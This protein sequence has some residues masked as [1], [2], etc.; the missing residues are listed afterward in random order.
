MAG[1]T[2]SLPYMQSVGDALFKL[3]AAGLEWLAS[4]WPQKACK[5]KF[6]RKFW[7]IT[8]TLILGTLYLFLILQ[9]SII[10]AKVL[11]CQVLIT[12]RDLGLKLEHV[13]LLMGFFIAIFTCIN[14]TLAESVRTRCTKKKIPKKSKKVHFCLY[15]IHLGLLGPKMTRS[16]AFY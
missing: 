8:E 11:I 7:R 5:S 2:D 10:E 3:P 1:G 13:W 15:P 6:W 12:Y 16:G 9:L 14:G 4:L